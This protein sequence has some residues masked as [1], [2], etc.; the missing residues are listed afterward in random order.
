M[1]RE[2]GTQVTALNF[3]SETCDASISQ[4]QFNLSSTGRVWF[5]LLQSESL[6]TKLPNPPL[7]ECGTCPP[8]SVHSTF[9]CR[10]SPGPA[11]CARS[12]RN[13]TGRSR[14]SWSWAA[15][16]TVDRDEHVL[17]VLQHR[18]DQKYFIKTRRGRNKVVKHK[19]ITRGG[20]DMTRLLHGATVHQGVFR[21]AGWMFHGL[22]ESPGAPPPRTHPVPSPISPWCSGETQIISTHLGLNDWASI[23][24]LLISDQTRSSPSASALFVCLRV[25][26]QIASQKIWQLISAYKRR[27]PPVVITHTSADWCCSVQPP[28][29]VINGL[30]LFLFSIKFIRLSVSIQ[31]RR[32]RERSSDSEGLVSSNQFQT[33]NSN[34]YL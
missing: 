11:H 28:P 20:V 7:W 10:T 25:H 24:S 3:S 30:P 34:N 18:V 8:L 27:A 23:S 22:P 15:P 17:V 4:S 1:L 26:W 13:G 12:R 16:L 14:L 5:V 2:C 19:D 33:G 9:W 29:T 32:W 21:K 31:F 6:T